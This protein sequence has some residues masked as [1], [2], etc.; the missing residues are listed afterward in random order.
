MATPTATP[1]ATHGAEPIP[2]FPE[3]YAPGMPFSLPE[4]QSLAADGLLTQFLIAATHCP[5]PR[6]P[7]NSGQAQQQGQFLQRSA[8]G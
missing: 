1:A 8:S 2:R 6:P 4:L 7:R 5:E 3:L